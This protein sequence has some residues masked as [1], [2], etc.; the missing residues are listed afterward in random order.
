VLVVFAVRV[1]VQAALQLLQA[2]H[3]VAG[4]VVQVL[5]TIATE[6]LGAETTLAR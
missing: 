4:R 1:A 2:V 3:T 6:V 5:A